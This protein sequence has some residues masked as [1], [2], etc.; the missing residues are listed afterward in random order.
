M[1]KNEPS[2]LTFTNRH[3]REIGDHPQD[4]EP[5]G[6]DDDSVVD[7]ISDVIPG[8]D[9]TPEEDAELPG[10]DTDFDAEPTGVEVDSD[11]VPQELTEV[12]GLGQQDPST[13]PTE[14]PS[15]EPPTEPRVET[16]APSPKKGMAARNARNRKQPEKYVPSM[17]G[18]KYTVALTQ[19]AASLKGSK[20]AMSM[21]QMSVKLM[22]KGE[23]RK[24][25]TVGM[26]MAQLS[27]KAA[28]KKWGQEAEYAITKEMK[29]L[30]WRDSYKPK[31]WHELTKK[32]KEQILESH[33]FVEQKRDGLIKA[34]KVIGGN[35][36]QDYIT[37]EDVSSPT[38][39][40]EAVMLTCVIDVQEDR[41]I[42]VVDIPNAFVQTVVD[43]EHA[44]HCV[45][46]RNRGPLVDIL[47]DCW[48]LQICA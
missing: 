8:V 45:I 27:M 22:S 11:Y 37:K 42:A 31:H 36:Q 39:T 28:I 38:V 41:Y 20:H 5:G 6:N 1:G 29:Q 12:D 46:V 23:H 3:G 7:L 25:D 40:A 43:E 13:A 21:A 24:A 47:A 35:K 48:R 33:I 14:E 9:P 15:A 32:Q 4:V 30:H 19:I 10:V 17:K 18:N 26:I 44:E 16:L 2:I 34:R